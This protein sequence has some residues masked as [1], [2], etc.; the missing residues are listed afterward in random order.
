MLV[1]EP[2]KKPLE[3]T[4]EN[5]QSV[6]E[7]RTD[8]FRSRGLDPCAECMFALEKDVCI[9]QTPPREWKALFDEKLLSEGKHEH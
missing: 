3:L 1:V 6:C 2:V 9:L 5:A 7:G 4:L 8:V